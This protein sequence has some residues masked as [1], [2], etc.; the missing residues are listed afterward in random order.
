MTRAA[1]VAA[2]VL[3]LGAAPARADTVAVS[4][5]FQSFEPAQVDVLP[6]DTVQWTNNSP[7][8]HTVTASAFDS[9]DLVPGATFAPAL[10]GLGTIAYHCTI[11]PGMIGEVDVRP[12]LLGPAPTAPVPPAQ[13]IHMTGRTALPA[14]PVVIERDTGSGF[15]PVAQATPAPDGTWAADVKATATGD[16]RAVDS[17][18]PSQTRHLVVIERRVDIHRTHR[19]LAVTVTPPLPY[20][21]LLLERRSR[22]R[23]GWFPAGRARLDYLSRASFRIRRPGRVRVLIV[24][25]DQWTPLAISPSMRIRSA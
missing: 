17:Q 4:A 1:L 2:A 7:R 3:A 5:L 10:P 6:S 18:G 16:L 9:G 13:N 14:E 23:F 11:H 8:T 24:D 25:K 15:A 19:G 20:G 12:V 21:R 22:E